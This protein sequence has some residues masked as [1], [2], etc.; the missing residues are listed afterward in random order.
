MK[1][2][3]V[4]ALALMLLLSTPQLIM[5]AES[6][7]IVPYEWI[8]PG[9][10]ASYKDRGGP[11]LFYPNHTEIM[12]NDEDEAFLEWTVVNRTGDIA[13]L[14]LTFHV[15]GRGH[16]IY[17]ESVPDGKV[18]ILDVATVAKAFG[19]QPYE[20]GFDPNADITGPEDLPDQKVTIK[21]VATVSKAFGTKSDDP[22]WNPKADIAPEE[23]RIMSTGVVHHRNL[24]LDIDVF[25]RETFLDG[26]PLGKTCFW[27]EPY[28]DIGDKVVLYG[29]PPEEIIG[30]MQKFK[31][32]SRWPGVTVYQVLLLQI[33]PFIMIDPEFDWDTG[34]GMEVYL[35]GSQP[36]DPDNP[37]SIEWSNGTKHWI[38]R[39]AAA[40]IA[41]ELNIGIPE[42]RL[43][44]ES[45]NI[46]LGPPS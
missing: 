11:F 46:Q 28:A 31:D 14:N 41:T 40:P 19:K 4:L 39:Y 42:Y 24:L 27:A 17:L 21:D 5:P 33:D 35:Q 13:Q 16:A 23:L 32:W 7:I 22:G 2:I 30:T 1:K 45:T 10:Y 37:H 25:S 36:L 12:V 18:S 20:W 9:A 8:V 6:D 44:L 26:K 43:R 15:E 3:A 34:M 38:Y 29:L